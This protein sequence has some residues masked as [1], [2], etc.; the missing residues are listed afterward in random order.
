MADATKQKASEPALQKAVEE[1]EK[2]GYSGF[3]PDPTPN[4]RYSLE[5][6]DWRTPETDPKAY[7]EAQQHLRKVASHWAEGE[8]D[9]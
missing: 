5:S 2:K 8:G 4:E 7:Q 3:V 6:N 1:E 9:F